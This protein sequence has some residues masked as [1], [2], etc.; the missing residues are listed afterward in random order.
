MP[1]LAGHV[2]RGPAGGHLQALVIALPHLLQGVGVQHAEP[3]TEGLVV[4]RA[5]VLVPEHQHLVIEHGLV[6]LGKGLVGQGPGQ[7]EALDLRADDRAEPVGP[8]GAIF[9]HRLRHDRFDG[10]KS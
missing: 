3:P 7:I 4:L 5:E 8:E 9:R 6:D 2:F 1:A 10:L